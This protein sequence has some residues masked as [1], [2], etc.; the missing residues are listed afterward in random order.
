ML[1]GPT[2]GTTST[3][4]RCAAATRSA[5]GSAT[6]GQ[7][8][9]LI[10][11]M[12]N[13]SRAGPSIASTSPGDVCSLRTENCRLSIS[14]LLSQALRKRRAVRNSST[15]KYL[16][17]RISAMLVA[18]STSQGATGAKSDGNNITRPVFIATK[19]E[20]NSDNHKLSLWCWWLASRLVVGRLWAASYLV[21]PL[22]ANPLPTTYQPP[23]LSNSL[24]TAHQPQ[25]T[26]PSETEVNEGSHSGCLQFEDKLHHYYENEQFHYPRRGDKALHHNIMYS[27][28]HCM[29]CYY[30]YHEN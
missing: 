13:P 26:N 14:I 29:S 20:K 30:K 12:S 19:L 9:S 28:R 27:R 17:S 7:P 23:T 15:T 10:M 4:F 2:K 25:T 16:T 24:P 8:A 11:P 6:A 22:K 5:P 21:L 3:P 18:G 1:D